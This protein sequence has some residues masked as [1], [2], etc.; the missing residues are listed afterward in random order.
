MC[1]E[2]SYDDSCCKRFQAWFPVVVFP[3]S[4]ASVPLFAGPGDEDDEGHRPTPLAS[5]IGCRGLTTLNLFERASSESCTRIC[6]YR[7]CSEY[8]HC[9]EVN[10]VSRQALV[11]VTAIYTELDRTKAQLPDQTHTESVASS[12]LEEKGK[13]QRSTRLVSARSQHKSAPSTGLTAD[14]RIHHL[15]CRLAQFL[16]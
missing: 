6:V 13:K 7:N 10:Q 1:L 11:D 8:V 5:F 16:H 15:R 9:V 14:F 2:L 12:S 4:C 3:K